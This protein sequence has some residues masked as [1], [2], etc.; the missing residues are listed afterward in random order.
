[1]STMK[2]KTVK[3]LVANLCRAIARR[4]EKTS[5][6][7]TQRDNQSSGT[8]RID[9]SASAVALCPETSSGRK[10]TTG[11]FGFLPAL[12]ITSTSLP[13]AEQDNWYIDKEWSVSESRGVHYDYNSTS[14][15]E[16]IFV[17]RGS[18]WDHSGRDIKIYDLNGTL[19]TTFGS[20][21][22]MDMTMDGNGTLYAVSHNRVVAFSKSPGR[23]VSVTVDDNG[24]NLYKHWGDHSWNMTFSGGGGTG[25]SAL[26]VLEQNATDTDSY[27]KF[28]TSVYVSKGGMNYSSEVNATLRSDHPK[29]G[30]T[31]EPQ[32]TVNLGVGWGENWSTGGFSKAQAIGISPISGD[33]FVA[34]AANHKIVVL[35]RNGTIKREF[36]SNGTAP[37]QFSFGYSQFRCSLDFLPDG[38]LLI[39]D[40]TYLHFY[41][42][43]GTFIERTNSG[44]YRASVAPDGTIL[45]YSKLRDSR[46]QSIQDSLPFNSHALT[47]FMPTG[48]LIESY[49]DKI[50]I[51]KRSYR[52]KGLPIRNVIPLPSIHGISQREGTNIVEIQFE[53]VDPDDSNATAGIIAAVNG[54][55]SNPNQWIVPSKFSDGTGSK[56]GTPI[57]TNQ[58]HQVAWDI[59]ADWGQQTGTLQFEVLCQDSRRSTPVDIHFLELP[60]ADGNLTISRS[61]ILD[62]DIVNY[63][64][65]QLATGNGSINLQNGEVRK[66]DGTLY[67]SNALQSSQEG[68]DHFMQSVG[69]RWAKTGEFQLALEAAT[70][71]IINRWA[72]TNQIKPRNLPGQVNEY[73]FDSKSYG[74]Q[75]WWVVKNS[76]LSFP[77][78]NLEKF[79]VNGSANKQFGKAISATDSMVAVGINADT[80]YDPE[81]QK[82]HLY[83]VSEAGK[84][85]AKAIV[86]PSDKTNNKSYYF[87]SS[88]SL[89][90]GKLAVGAK[91]A[92]EENL[93][94]GA[95]YLFDVNGST[96][97]QI[98]RITPSD[99]KHNGLFGI[100]VASS[101]NLLVVG[102]SG[103]ENNKGAAYIYNIEVNGS[104][105]RL[106][107]VTNPDG[108]NEDHFGLSTAVGNN[109]VAVG[110]PYADVEL[111]GKN[112][113]DLGTVL[114]FKVEANGNVSKTDTLT[115]PDFSGDGHHFGNAIAISNGILAIGHK[116]NYDQETGW[117]RT[118]V[119]HMY[120]IS[121]QGKAV[122]STSIQSPF[123]RNDAYFGESVA[124]DG[125]RLLV[126]AR[127]E[128][129]VSG[130]SNG[131]AGYLYQLSEQGK[132]SLIERFVH[133]S[134]KNDDDFGYSLGLSGRNSFIGAYR[135]NLSNSQSDAGSAVFFRSSF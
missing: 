119:V 93:S 55:F 130:N 110:T 68:R 48:D 107:K 124:M 52:T 14:G 62:Q 54:E 50:R 44:K 39:A 11:L 95:V 5:A 91:H 72:A 83:Q 35:D 115:P 129:G 28:V 60:F 85:Q 3:T 103:N 105:T 12:A 7:D 99:G 88:M 13:A 84:L 70:P 6:R 45:S 18:V 64:K 96:P 90:S 26:A 19:K 120:K 127:R 100:S 126:G 82:V 21:N 20:G 104:S 131:G 31:V 36:G 106:A 43:D 87:G 122:F 66:N 116:G 42:E 30:N 58:I 86:E 1:M 79:D 121:P 108:K 76:T 102:A 33:L 47:A 132:P 16:R 111:N 101:A 113:G 74:N 22:F 118:G 63:F 65:F 51:W 114:L 77:D 80:A 92:Y 89:D 37:G 41:K 32:F 123:K 34:D 67:L 94:L 125:N 23:I 15:Q 24:S 10:L 128:G 8:S 27:N 97:Q 53:I 98:N 46:G 75:A 135:H 49:Q 9:E 69:H 117:W 29:T 81:Y 73:G 38:T 61:P 134:G 59:G 78:F 57:A 109:I 112:H 17:G 25:A 4:L 71:G 56:I 133:P 2:E 40:Q